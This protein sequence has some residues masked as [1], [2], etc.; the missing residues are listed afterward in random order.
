MTYT[1]TNLSPN[2]FYSVAD[3][4][5]GQSYSSGIW[6]GSTTTSGDN[7]VVTTSPLTAAGTY[8]G[9]VKATA[10][11]SFEMCSS[12][13]MASTFKVLPVTFIEFKGVHANGANV[14]TWKTGVEANTVRFEI[15]RS[16]D[17]AGFV[18][19][20]LQAATGNNSA[21][22]FTDQALS[23]PAYYYRLKVVDADGKRSYSRT[24][25]LKDNGTSTVLNT[26]R[27][28]PF[29]KEMTVSLTLNTPQKITLALV[30]AAGR[31][32][33]VK[34]VAGVQ[35]L[36]TVVLSGLGSLSKG[37]YIL[38]VNC[39]GSLFQEKVLKSE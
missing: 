12:L 28:N 29:V 24:I 17:G 14:L 8:N 27:P 23:A 36:N 5:T 38:R 33:A 20:G 31:A 34:Q 35:G 19:I 3:A 1:I 7:I 9:V 11:T 10:V 25:V 18:S 2:T 15:Q 21:Y 30:D 32:V 39:D 37:M 22:A 6:T 16:T 26:V 4:V 13:A